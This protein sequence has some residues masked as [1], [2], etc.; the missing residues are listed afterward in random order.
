MDTEKLFRILKD[1][2]RDEEGLLIGAKI[3]ALRASVAQNNA[4]GFQAAKT[5]L[6]ELKISIET[7]SKAYTFSQTENL[8]L[9]KIGGVSYYGKGL[10]RVLDEI[11]ASPSFEVLAKLDTCREQRNDFI[12]KYT[13]LSAGF[14]DIGIK[15]YRPSSCEVGIV[16]PDGEGELTELTKRM[17]EFQLLLSALAEAAG[18]DS[19]NVKITRV[20]NGTLEWFSLQP[21]NVTLILT[22]LLLNV[23]AIYD[24][25]T[26]FRN[27]I[28]ETD[29]DENLSDEAKNSIKAVLKKESDKIKEEILNKLPERIL[30]EVKTNLEEG[31][32]NEVRNQI[33]I[34]VKGVFRWLELGIE[35]DVIP[36][37]VDGIK[38][39]VAADPESKTLNEGIEKANLHLAEIYKLPANIKKLPF[40]L[41]S[42][43]SNGN[44]KVIKEEN[45]S[46]RESVSKKEM[47]GQAS[48]RVENKNITPQPQKQNLDKGSENKISLG[49]FEQKSGEK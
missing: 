42:G 28:D 3:E 21:Y 44:S 1:M 26:K 2:Q 39:D 6:D 43:D 18:E 5:S 35:V 47:G 7:I 46:P 17:K 33:R 49:E 32:K 22:T 8:L 38:S 14:L 27:K 31:R 37:R 12:A 4:D 24:K 10:I 45:I 40:E 15:E 9:E 34:G 13:K 19:N 30:D 16:L 36:I 20:S 23:S 41:S 25:I 48:P 29:R 11:F